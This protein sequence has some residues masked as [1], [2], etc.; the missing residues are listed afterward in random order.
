[1]SG[2]KKQK[3]LEIEGS[4]FHEENSANFGANMQSS[5]HSLN[6]P[7]SPVN[8]QEVTETGLKEA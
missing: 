4:G 1:M 7:P 3:N 5:V 2:E 8:V 6:M